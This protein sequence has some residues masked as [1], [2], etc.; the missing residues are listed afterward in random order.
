MVSYRRQIESFWSTAKSGPSR[1]I[2]EYALGAARE[3]KRLNRGSL[4]QIRDRSNAKLGRDAQGSAPEVSPTLSTKS[5][6]VTFVTFG[7]CA[8][9]LKAH[10][11]PLCEITR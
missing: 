3:L 8:V 6:V 9:I 10:Y 1:D 7:G 5:G 4:I 2:H 11:G